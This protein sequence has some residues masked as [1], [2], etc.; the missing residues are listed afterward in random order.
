MNLVQYKSAG[1]YLGSMLYRNKLSLYTPY[2]STFY[3]AGVSNSS[4]PRG[5]KRHTMTSRGQGRLTGS[6][7]VLW[8]GNKDLRIHVTQRCPN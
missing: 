5:H 8:L 6:K 3:K 2:E 1:I 4:N 7:R